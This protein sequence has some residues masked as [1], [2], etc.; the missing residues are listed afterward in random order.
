MLWK[1]E[2]DGCY[3]D[4]FAAINPDS[5]ITKLYMEKYI[6]FNARE[7]ENRENRSEYQKI[8]FT[9]KSHCERGKQLFAEE[10]YVDAM[11]AFN[12]ALIFSPYRYEEMAF[13]Y[14]NRSACFLHLN[15]PNECLVDVAWAKISNYPRH[16]MQNL[17]DIA[18]AGRVLKEKNIK[19]TPFAMAEPALSF[20]ENEKFGGVADCLEIRRNGKF[21]HHVVTTCD[22]EIGQTIL[23]EH[24]FSIAPRKCC[25]Q[26]F[27]RCFYC[28]SKFKNFISCANCNAGFYCNKR[29]MEKAFHQTDS[30]MEASTDCKGKFDLVVKTFLN[31]ID[32][33][34]DGN[35]LMSTVD[36]LI[37]GN[38]AANDLTAAQKNFCSI[39][40][41]ALNDN[42]FTEEQAKDLRSKSTFAYLAMTPFPQ[43]KEMFITK[44]Q[45]CFAQHLV[46]HLFH[47]TEHAIDLYELVRAD[48]TTPMSKYTI[49]QFASGMY[50]FGCYINHSCVPNICWYSIDDRLICKVIQPIKKGEQIFR[51]YL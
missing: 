10:K 26:H 11:Q 1:K 21:G 33:F 34:P 9:A 37:N 41:L 4:I 30:N 46:L 22:L 31:I 17:D 47:I 16:L 49:H 6:E 14:A 28:C 19:P 8:P 18:A 29:C 48:N 38:N 7:Y 27:D 51:S 20:A 45:R 24:P 35:H 39:F 36:S 43:F 2:R 40:R 42:K 3:I 25:G 12:A 13:A 15:M 23:V 5:P 50:P 44:E 32:A